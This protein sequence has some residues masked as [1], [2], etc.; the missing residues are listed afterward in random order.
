MGIAWI[1]L[2]SVSSN[3][4]LGESGAQPGDVGRG[5]H[6]FFATGG[7]TCHTNLP[8]EG[9]DA[10]LLAGGRGLKTPFGVFYS[11]NITPDPE[12][13]IGDWSDADFMRA[14]RE[15]LSPDGEHYFPVFPYTSFSGLTDQDLVDLRAYLASLPAIR[16]ENRPPDAPFPFS[17]RATLAG[18]KWLNFEPVPLPDAP[19]RSE[20]W[21]R[22]RY[23]VTAAAHCGECH[24]PRTLT[25]GLDRSMWLAGSREGPEGELAPNITPDP[26]T[27]IGRWSVADL[28][29]Y[30]E[31]GIKPDGDD[32]QGLMAE[33]IEHGYSH[34][35]KSDLEAIAV[36][37]KALPAIEHDLR[38]E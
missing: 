17:W 31:M 27:G 25:G 3:P 28:V 32:T 8:G 9:K 22:G 14:M 37:L 29:W 33:V 15:G 23:L 2:I 21:I 1:V 19:D 36:Y 11:T 30:L 7:C 10:P 24:T 4:V 26:K 38:R 16:R 18:W 13:G 6:V 5:R 34:L 35:P 20:A 12:T